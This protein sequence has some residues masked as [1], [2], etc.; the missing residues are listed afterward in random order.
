MPPSKDKH[1]LARIV[2]RRD[3][4][5]DLWRLRVDPG[6]AF[7]YLAGQYATLGVE[8]EGKRI[9]RSYSIVSSPYEKTLEFFV[10]LAPHGGLTPYL[11]KLTVGDTVLCRK[12]AKGRFTLDLSS[13]RTEHLLV[14]T[15]TGIAPFVSFVRTLYRDWKSGNSSMPGEHKLYCLQGGSRSWEF[16]YREELERFAAEVP[17]FKYVATISR[18]WGD[19]A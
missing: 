1:F 3:L 6:G 5:P 2:E 17:W 15:V 12:I 18:P 9:E 8:Q 19:A 16:G 10:E 13:G 11:H 14:S 7:N 4:S